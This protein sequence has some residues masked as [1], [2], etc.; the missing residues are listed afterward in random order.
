MNNRLKKTMIISTLV[1]IVI[2]V[3]VMIMGLL[4][5]KNLSYE[6][7]EQKMADAAIEYYGAHPKKLPL[8]EESEVSIDVKTLVEGEYIK[9][10][11]KLND[12]DKCSGEIYVTL[13]NG[14]HVYTP[15]LNCDNYKTETLYNYIK[16]KEN[17]VE[18]KNSG[19]DGLYN[20]NDTLIYR[21]ENVNNYVSFD[22]K[23]WR[24][25]RIDSNNNIRMIQAEEL[26][27]FVWDDRYNVDTD[28][29]TGYNKFEKS[30]MQEHFE[31]ISSGAYG[32]VLTNGAKQYMVSDYLC[33]DAKNNNF[34]QNGI[35]ECNHKSEEKYPFTFIDISEYFLASVD[36]NCN[37]FNNYS[38][39]NYNY[40]NGYA[41]YW[42]MNSFSENSYQAYY[43]SRGAWA[44]DVSEEYDIRLVVTLTK[45][46]LYSAGD[47]RQSNPYVIK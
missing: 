33:L 31:N 36:K 4:L 23:L 7:I 45:H 6:K 41:S 22:G 28:E 9:P 47:G 43:I 30:R 14:N 25:L 3:I 12:E 17:I 8:E 37:S 39:N 18:D 34:N 11:E 16:N 13:R 15:Y 44:D 29:N 10:L 2:F 24:I 38:C 1:I 26:G 5:N 46:S 20:Y 19:E 40:L 32:E 21:G 27:E 35:I 42:A